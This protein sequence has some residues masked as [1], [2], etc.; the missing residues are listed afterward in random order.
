MGFPEAQTQ[1]SIPGLGLSFTSFLQES[2]KCGLVAVL[3]Y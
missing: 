3:G 2:P 1:G